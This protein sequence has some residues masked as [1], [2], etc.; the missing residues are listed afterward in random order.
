[1][2]SLLYNFSPYISFYLEI[3]TPIPSPS[4]QYAS[5]CPNAL[6]EV[7]LLIM[8][9]SCSWF[10]LVHLSHS[11]PLTLSHDLP[12]AYPHPLFLSCLFQLSIYHSHFLIMPSSTLSHSLL[13]SLF[14][15]FS[16]TQ[17]RF[18]HHTISKLFYNRRLKLN[19][20]HVLNH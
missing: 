16:L 11:L 4:P 1:M 10:L 17:F 19:I 15:L 14:F 3:L 18:V 13:L 6:L 8:K 20:F 5:L 9:I 12:Y 7:V 2:L